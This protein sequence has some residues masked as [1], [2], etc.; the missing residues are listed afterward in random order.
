MRILFLHPK[1]WSGE[2]V[3]LQEL[4][5]RGHAVCVLEESREHGKRAYADW[6]REPGDGIR[7]LWHNPSL[8]ALRLATWL[9]DRIFR[10]AF[11]GRNLVHR[12]CVVAEAVRYFR[13][14]VILATDGFS[15]AIPAALAKSLGMIGPRLVVSY[16]GGDILDCAEAEVGRRRTPMTDWLIRTSFG[17]IDALRPL[18]PNLQAVLVH[19]GAQSRRLH[20]LPVH[21]VADR[22]ALADVRA[23]R[24]ECR[25]EICRRYGMRPAAPLI[26]TL[27]GNQ[28]GKGLHVLARA[29][30]AVIKRI[31]EAR[32]LLCGPAHPWLDAAVWPQLDRDG[33]R[34]TVIAAGRIDGPDV[35]RHLAAADLHV[36]P[37]LCEGLNMVTVEAAA[38]GT[39]TIGTDG[40]GIAH[41]IERCGAGQV[42]P[43][44][45]VDPLADAILGALQ[46]PGRIRLWSLALPAMAEEFALERIADSLVALLRGDD[47]PLT[48][49]PSLARP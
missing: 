4:V 38:V 23:R 18:S 21:L 25:A 10:Q 15:Y 27:S 34:E 43:H 37:T 11:E 49:H 16:I 20:M 42:V 7:T 26:V 31:P 8:G 3:M 17:G 2:Y 6:Y 1:A 45:Q 46:E 48:S 32:W 39:P 5:R 12:M 22:A 9:P 19:D 13:P 41:W 28:K 33:L 30:P 14:D 40:A 47:D 35:F 36:N 29:W 24:S 44:S